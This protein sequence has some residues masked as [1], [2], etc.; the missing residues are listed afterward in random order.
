MVKKGRGEDK[1][2]KKEEGKTRLLKR[3]G[4]IQDGKKERRE[5]KTVKKEIWKTKR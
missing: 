5:D 3:K 2:V 1:T 4:G